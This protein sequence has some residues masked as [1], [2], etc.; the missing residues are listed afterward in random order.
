MWPFAELGLEADADERAVKRAYAARL[1]QTRPE[2][3]PQG[4]QALHAAY[5]AALASCRQREAVP[6]EAAR[7]VAPMPASDEPL[8]RSDAAPSSGPARPASTVPPLPAARFDLDAFVQQAIA[9]AG[10]GDPAALEHWLRGIEA[11]W[12]LDTK[13]QAGHTLVSAIYRQAPPMPEACLDALLVFFGLDNALAGHDPLALHQLR[14]RTDLAWH[15]APARRS[16]LAIALRMNERRARR[17][18]DDSLHQLQRPFHWPQVLLRGLFPAFAREIATLVQRLCSGHLELLPASF[19]RRQLG[20]WLAAV[21]TRFVSRP[22]LALA[23]ARMLAVLLLSLPVG[24]FFGWVAA[25]SWGDFDPAAVGVTALTVL[26]LGALVFAFAAWSQLVRWQ[27]G[28]APAGRWLGGLHVGLVP[29]LTGIGLLVEYLA[30]APLA[31]WPVLLLATWLAMARALRG[32]DIPGSV[33]TW[34]WI[35]IVMLSPMAHL[36]A[37]SSLQPAWFTGLFA[38]LALCGWAA[39]LWR[40]RRAWRPA[41]AR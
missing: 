2:D 15:L 13:A 7:P 24:V 16:Q 5:Q 17:S 39:A 21:D 30:D 11:L 40:Q 10:V 8:T 1:R 18:L 6:V 29:L 33:R 41:R 31:G 34:L 12:S 36:L 32:L 25:G 38:A 19:A 3:D 14:R 9:H 26:L 35:G 37:Q 23:G 27:V 22:R 20:F 28:P 4:F